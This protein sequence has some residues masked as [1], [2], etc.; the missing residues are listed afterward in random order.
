M[1][2][3]AIEQSSIINLLHR[4]PLLF[5]QQYHLI[6]EWNRISI[7]IGWILITTRRT[8]QNLSMQ[9]RINCVSLFYTSS[10]DVLSFK[11]IGCRVEQGKSIEGSSYGISADVELECVDLQPCQ[12][13]CQSGLN[14]YLE[15]RS[16]IEWNQCHCY[17]QNSCRIQ[18]FQCLYYIS[19][20]YSLNQPVYSLTLWYSAWVHFQYSTIT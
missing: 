16:T 10:T 6:D 14:E 20:V 19:L 8:E 12:S 9:S 11:M 7:D 4:L 3:I 1:P 13:E 17:R 15:W 5:E 18:H 2:E